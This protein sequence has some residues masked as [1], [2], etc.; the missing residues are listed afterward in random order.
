MV[1]LAPLQ[2]GANHVT[3]SRHKRRD[4]VHAYQIFLTT[5]IFATISSTAMSQEIEG[6]SNS[7]LALKFVMQTYSN[8]T[9]VP[10]YRR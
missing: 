6:A 8:A 5:G 9:H 1:R 4:L 3:V 2:D 10:I 7:E